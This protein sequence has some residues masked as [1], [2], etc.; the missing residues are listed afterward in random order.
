MKSL[1]KSS[2]R[3]TVSEKT[4][5]LLSGIIVA[6]AVI[7]LR[8]WHLAVIE[9]DQKLEEA[10]KP[11]KR[12]IPEYVERATI[13]DR[14]GKIL[15]TN[16][17]QY[18]VSIAYSA[19]REIPSRAW[20]ENSQGIKELIPV[21]K[22]YIRRLAELLSREL[23]LDQDFIEDV[24]HSKASVLGVVPYLLQSNISEQVYLKLKMI[25][26]DW[27]GLHVDSVVRR[28][29]P[30]GKIAAD[31]IGYVGPI[32]TGE[33][34]R[35]TQEL[36]KLRE[37]IRAYEEGENPNF[38]E[39]LA[40]IDQVR[41]LLESLENRAYSLNALVGKSGI[42]ALYDS[43]LRGKIGKSTVLVD[44]RG[45]FI[46]DVEEAVPVVPGTRLQLSLSADLQA[47][48][49]KLLL[50]HEQA[51]SFRSV[52]SM[53]KRELLPPLFPWIKGGAIIAL[54]PNNGEILAMAS[55]PRYCNND[56]V[57]MRVAEDPIATRSEI[58]RW[59][60]GKEHIAEL[61]DRKTSLRR[62]RKDFSSGENF[63]EQLSLTF[64]NYLDLLFPNN[65]VVKLLLKKQDTIGS[66]IRIQNRVND[67]LTLFCYDKRKCSCSAIF[68][69]VFPREE[70]HI[71]TKK[72]TSVS[73]QEWLAQCLKQHFASI[74]KVKKDLLEA[75]EKLPANY[76][77][78][79]YVDLLRLV[80]DP[81][82][83]SPNLF[84]KIHNLSL[85]EFAELQGRY[86]ALR[87]AFSK[88]IEE[89]FTETEFK[90]WRHE[91][92]AQFLANKRKEEEI[93]KQRFPTPY[94]DYLEKERKKQ[95]WA[96]RKQYL[97]SF[98]AYL[99]SGDP[100]KKEFLNPYYNTLSLW[101]E[102]LS[103]GAHKALPWYE[104]YLFLAEHLTPLSKE[105]Q[106]LFN[107]FRGFDDLQRHLLGEYPLTIVKNSPQKEQDLAAAFYPTYGY[108]YLR[109]HSFGQAA[110]LGSIFKL[111]S[112]YSVL[113]QRFLNMPGEELTKFFVLIDKNSFGY[114]ASKPH[115][116]FFKDGSPIP[117]FFRGGSLP[118]NDFS[119]RGYIDM[120]SA[121]EMSSNT[122]FS[123]LVG[124]YLSDPED[125]YDA[126]VLFG[127]GEKTGIGLP[128][129]YAGKLPKDISYNRSG[130]YATAIGQHT[131][132]VT[133]LQ[134]AT[135]LAA[136]VNGG[137]LY[138]P[139]LLLREGNLPVGLSPIKKHQI[140]MPE[141]VV[142]VLKQGMHQ[143]I[144]GNFGTARAIREQFSP[145][146]LS[147][148]IGKT[149]TAES[150][151]RVGLDREYGTMKMKDVWFAAVS[152]TDRELSQ[153]ELVVV[154]YLRLGEFGRD[155]APIAVRMIEMWEKIQRGA[156][157]LN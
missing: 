26:K 37:C 3:L 63:D 60:E 113:S 117:I 20:R 8:L 44:R 10:F 40:S 38:P 95:Y 22:Y 90:T 85:L 154:V 147:R 106:L 141:P 23:H 142:K 55:S 156:I 104:H 72:I 119:G 14:F 42:E 54:N 130:L 66:A 76:D 70:G 58:Y 100:F 21:R 94:V 129:E 96:F 136:F 50:E 121:L 127:F 110:T 6:L 109:S 153:P 75:F 124:E 105:L 46:Q 139:S 150:I 145:D 71:L 99:I 65:S 57:K 79:L 77:K 13:C 51:E 69:V 81:T 45:N 80:I 78:I 33:Y 116:G 114:T 120:I 31:V 9:H 152:F 4:N 93:K 39:G 144:W 47:F 123:L 118:G 125:L 137:T 17:L 148:I 36:S 133:P 11:Q 97:D 15:A 16:Q 84:L 107:A 1:K 83:V 19:I 143:V 122:Y 131:L 30:Q 132:V 7:V 146:I 138:V 35:I 108:G 27:P 115:V 68:D 128:G 140:F 112:A 91:H 59:L 25:A 89:I 34:K 134:V 43:Q 86:I 5:K 73:Q 24:I 32:N 135:M 67:L 28:Y 56:F 126:A 149:S 62:E 88:I 98:L 64:E 12:V 49:E 155:A 92:F 18:D 82:K 48:A 111:V 2:K 157:F 74:E 52:N 151:M 103:R 41:A 87:E 102:E 29:Y 61:Y 101:R 53:K